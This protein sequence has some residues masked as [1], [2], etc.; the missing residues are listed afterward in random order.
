VSSSRKYKDE[1]GAHSR[2][3]VM[4]L[5]EPCTHPVQLHG[6]CGVCGADLTS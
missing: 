1:E 5:K 3:P 4:W 2:K 6:L